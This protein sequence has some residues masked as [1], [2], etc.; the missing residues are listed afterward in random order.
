MNYR[1]AVM[2]L[3][4]V[5]CL[6]LASTGFSADK[7]APHSASGVHPMMTK[8]AM[9]KQWLTFDVR[10]AENNEAAKQ[11]TST[12]ESHG[13][14]APIQE[15]KGKPFR[16]T[17]DTSTSLDL[18]A[19]G[20]AIMSVKEPQKS[21]TAP[22]LDLVVFATLNK[23]SAQKAINRLAKIQ[24]V[25]AKNSHADTTRGEMSVRIVGG[26]QV[27]ASDIYNAL[28]ETGLNPSFTKDASAHHT[29]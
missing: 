29:S 10:G 5:V 6:A 4:L 14:Y 18:G 3:S 26:Q 7:T 9:S 27:R 23:D 16:L 28:R 22:S 1:C 17:A 25:D 2:Q 11:L 12:L 24:G 20:K 13:L 19:L 15:S 21:S 8:T